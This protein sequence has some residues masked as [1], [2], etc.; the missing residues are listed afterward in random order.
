[1]WC[2]VEGGGHL[3]ERVVGQAVVEAPCEQG[4]VLSATQARRG[5]QEP[6]TARQHHRVELREERTVSTLIMGPDARIHSRNSSA[7]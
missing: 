5:V 6:G 4:E 7:G 3:S 1:M 2:W